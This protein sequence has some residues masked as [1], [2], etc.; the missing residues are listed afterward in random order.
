MPERARLLLGVLT[1]YIVPYR[2][3]KNGISPL[4][5]DPTPKIFVLLHSHFVFSLLCSEYT[6]YLRE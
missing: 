3:S 4:T 2:D 1:K 6:L 5:L